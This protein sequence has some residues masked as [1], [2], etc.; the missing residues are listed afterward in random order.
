MSLEAVFAVVASMIMLPEVPAPTGR[1]W[2]GMA[3]IFVAIVVSQIPI[4]Y[5]KRSKTGN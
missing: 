4:R 3:L 1:E 5:K 2:G